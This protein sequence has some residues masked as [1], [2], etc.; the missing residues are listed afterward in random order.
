MCTWRRPS[1]SWPPSRSSWPSLSRR[2][3]PELVAEP[4]PEPELVAEP[5]PGSPR[6]RPLFAVEPTLALGP[7]SDS[8]PDPGYWHVAAHPAR[9]LVGSD[10][11]RAPLRLSRVPQGPLGPRM[12]GRARCGSLPATRPEAAGGR[13]TVSSSDSTSISSGDSCPHQ[14]ELGRCG[15]QARPSKRLSGVGVEE[16]HPAPRPY[17]PES[18]RA[19]R[20]WKRDPVVASRGRTGGSTR[21]AHP[22]GIASAMPV[23]TLGA[24]PR[25]DGG[26]G[27]T[28]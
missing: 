19:G 26:P 21:P 15:R 28:A 25:P 17:N 20:V 4:T 23:P 13:G 22:S 3:E 10:P 9:R 6:P 5:T 27:S 2:P 14:D 12:P 18:I 24:L 7:V 16:Q 11:R 8:E 1:R